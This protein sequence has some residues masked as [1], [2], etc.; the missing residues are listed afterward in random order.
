[1]SDMTGTKATALEAFAQERDQDFLRFDYQGHG[2]SSGAFAEGTIGLWAEDAIAALDNLTEGPQILVG[3]SM[4]GWIMLLTALA[5]PERIAGLVGI[6]AA[7]D[8]TEGMWASFSPEVRTKLEQ[9]GIHQEPSDYDDEPYTITYALIEDG[10][11]QCLLAKPIPLTCPVRLLQGMEDTAVPWETALKISNALES[12]DV[13]VTLVK[14]G[15]HRLSEP[16][17]LE[18]L[19]QIVGRLSDGL[20]N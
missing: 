18:R 8:F 11:Q 7:P 20:M 16:H 1:M 13:E 5:R 10:R 19:M 3:S 4:G 14:N 12:G 15:D 6:A 17:D 2:E 9:T